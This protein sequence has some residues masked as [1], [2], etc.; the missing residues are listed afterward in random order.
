MF[1]IKEALRTEHNGQGGDEKNEADHASNENEKINNAH[2]MSDDDRNAFDIL[3]WCT[4][5]T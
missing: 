2:Y 4:L 3:A 1:C 5:T